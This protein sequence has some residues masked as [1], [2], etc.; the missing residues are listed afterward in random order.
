MPSE[1]AERRR[2]NYAYYK[3]L[4]YSTAEARRLRDVSPDKGF[5]EIQRTERRLGRIR[6]IDRSESVQMRLRAIRDEIRS[7]RRVGVDT[8]QPASRVQRIEQF[9]EWSDTRD[10]FPPNVQRQIERLNV[11]A[12]LSPFAAYG[13]RVFFHL[14]VNGLDLAEAREVVERRDT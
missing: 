12:G 3:S 8:D 10:G 2:Q 7:R 5:E 9:R 14:Y 1:R 6:A 13:Y 11:D 4:G